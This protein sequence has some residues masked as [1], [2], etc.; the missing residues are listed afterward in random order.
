MRILAVDPGS[1]NI[2]IALS[3][4]TGTIATPLGVIL[5]ASRQVDAEAIA[6]L[7]RLHGAGKV[8]VG[9]ALDEHGEPT[10][11]GQR[12][13]RLAAAIRRNSDIPVV[14]W[15]ESFSTQDARAAREA[16]GSPQRKRRGHLDELAAAIIL[17]SYLD[18]SARDIQIGKDSTESNESDPPFDPTM[19]KD[20]PR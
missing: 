18:S 17:Q 8:V 5:H 19:T 10:F 9:Q 2:G 1:K 20:Q 15:D 7:A 4:P 14:L 16:L 11:E 6:A 3:D 12:A 13:A